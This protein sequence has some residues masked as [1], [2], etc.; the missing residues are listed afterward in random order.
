MSLLHGY[1][2]FQLHINIEYLKKRI[3]DII[4]C[5][6]I[7][8]DIQIHILIV[9]VFYFSTCICIF[10]DKI[11]LVNY[12]FELSSQVIVALNVW[13]FWGSFWIQILFILSFSIGIFLLT[14]GCIICTLYK[15]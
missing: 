7:H 3:L 10:F 8:N 4:I 1:K 11:Y 13:A 5:Y 6:Q 15:N 9:H 14:S 12:I 2:E